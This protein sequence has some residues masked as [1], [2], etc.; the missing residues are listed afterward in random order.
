MG[1]QDLPPEFL[2]S[3]LSDAD[4]ARIAQISDPN[5]KT[6]VGKALRGGEWALGGLA[7]VASRRLWLP[8]AK[9]ATQDDALAQLRLDRLAE[10]KAHPIFAGD[11]A[12]AAGLLRGE[13]TDPGFVKFGK[14]VG[15]FALSIAGDPLTYI[16]IANLTKLGRATKIAK[17]AVE[18]GRVIEP[19]SK[20]AKLIEEVF[21]PD[22]L[23]ADPADVKK[24][25]DE[26]ALKSSEVDPKILAAR[27]R[28]MGLYEEAK[29]TGTVAWFPH[30]DNIEQKVF[31]GSAEH[32]KLSKS[33]GFDPLVEGKVR[34]HWSTS[35][36][37]GSQLDIPFHLPEEAQ[38]EL[39]ALRERWDVLQKA[40]V[41][42]S[43]PYVAKQITGIVE[44]TQARHGDQLAELLNNKAPKEEIAALL[45]KQQEE[46]T[47]LKVDAR[48]K[49]EGTHF[50][51]PDHN[52][53]FSEAVKAAENAYNA[54][55]LELL[56]QFPLTT[57]VLVDK[58]GKETA[59]IPELL[60]EAGREDLIPAATERTVRNV[61]TLRDAQ[62]PTVNAVL[63]NIRQL[64]A[65]LRRSRIRADKIEASAKLFLKTPLPEG[66]IFDPNAPDIVEKVGELVKEKIRK[67]PTAAGKSL[68]EQIKTGER[69]LLAVSLPGG[70]ELKVPVLGQGPVAETI[71]GA[72]SSLNRIG[73]VNRI[74]KSFRRVFSNATGNPEYDK[75]LTTMKAL[76]LHK[77][78]IEI[79]DAAKV[80]VEM[81]AIAG[82]MGVPVH[83]VEK[84]VSKVVDTSTAGIPIRGLRKILGPIAE[85]VE[86]GSTKGKS[87][88]FDKLQKALEP[89]TGGEPIRPGEVVPTPI[90]PD[91]ILPAPASP[92]KLESLNQELAKDSYRVG[93]EGSNWKANLDEVD[94]TDVALMNPEN[95]AHR[96]LMFRLRSVVGSRI[97]QI[98]A[99]ILKGPE[100]GR[101]TELMSGLFPG[102]IPAGLKDLEGKTVKETLE[103]LQLQQ[104]EYEDLYDAVHTKLDAYLRDHPGTRTRILGGRPLE[105]RP[106]QTLETT[107]EKIQ[108]IKEEGQVRSKTDAYIPNPLGKLTSEM[109]TRKKALANELRGA[110]DANGN[111]II[112][113]DIPVS[114]NPEFIWHTITTEARGDIEQYLLSKGRIGPGYKQSEFRR[115][116]LR[117]IRAHFTVVDPAGVDRLLHEGTIT[118]KV[119]AGMKGKRG[120]DKLDELLK[121]G[122]ISEKQYSDMVFTLGPAEVNAATNKGLF[123]WNKG[124]SEA[125]FFIADPALSQGLTGVRQQQTITAIQF[126]NELKTRGIGVP[127]AI[128]PKDYLRAP[129]GLP[130]LEGYLFPPEVARSL[131]KWQEFQYNDKAIS[132]FL[133]VFDTV[134]DAWKAWTLAIFPAYHTRNF[135]GNLWNNW[136]AG[137]SNPKWYILAQRMQLGEKLNFTDGLGKKWSADELRNE[138]RKLGILDKGFVGADVQRTIAKQLEAGK[139]MTPGRGNKVVE[140]GFKFGQG[141]ENNARIGHF[142]AKLAEGYTTEDAAMSVKKYLFD[143]GDLTDFERKVMKRIFPFYTWT[144]KNVPLQLEHLITQ[145]AKFSVVYK[146]RRAIEDDSTGPNEKY[147]P[148]W[149]I[150]NYPTRIRYDKKSKQYEYFLANAW[151]PAMDLV[152]LL[153][154][155]ETAAN[156]L[157]PV[158]KE[159]LQQLFNYD[160][161]LKK[162]IQTIPG[163]KER[164]NL[165]PLHLDLPARITHG[166]RLVR[167]LSEIDKLS[168]P[169]ADIISKVSEALTSKTYLY[170][171]QKSKRQNTFE[172]RSRIRDLKVALK[173]EARRT[174]RNEKE[175]ER[176]R[177]L[178]RQ[179]AQEF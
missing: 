12:S 75:L 88:A 39:R 62:I 102:R 36:V 13:Q 164:L 67:Q 119:A 58:I 46:M 150:E 135:V 152:K 44:E 15:R 37:P 77:A 6:W 33:L 19:G 137:I 78:G 153:E 17:S 86:V 146:G 141:I 151:L 160:Y 123:P 27:K 139:W 2:D 131:A 71:A 49:L 124:P 156:M 91:R 177:K 40:D 112:L 10:D 65:V 178:I 110:I 136:L 162:K 41:T 154:L 14:G 48:N 22:F 60:R 32:A 134:Q 90:R 92:G 35:K 126:Y 114:T 42:E 51:D 175:M 117:L 50:L 34:L 55:K 96:A 125:N 120:L 3:S 143:Y 111:R 63:D 89:I 5:P 165:G 69:A 79:Q 18:E 176:I 73:L 174:P 115:E 144:R 4:K 108:R 148:Q 130:M 26:A 159:L 179:T 57:R 104:A 107:L 129:K 72:F 28:E 157:T 29:R 20:A 94:S 163:Q 167:L 93:L 122:R 138:M 161:F 166:A 81:K 16:P 170:N 116:A 100:K 127:A 23:K 7:N 97:R 133:K 76:A 98:K 171:E 142:L 31:V 11:V 83:E 105:E 1:L 43:T 61:I 101:P 47:F 172:V 21:G 64:N 106:V 173:R 149:V 70:V 80:R 82:K 147:L 74:E 52:A 99:I 121:T 145:P 25:L 128:A 158:P 53:G 95:E 103:N 8:L 9:A 109:L 84:Y 168:K 45:K 66:K 169:E 59:K 87:E 24:I 68:V 30:P 38:N 140:L 113:P 56:K 132:D 54:R 155:H 118:E 85:A